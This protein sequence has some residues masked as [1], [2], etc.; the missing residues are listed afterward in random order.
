MKHLKYGESIADAVQNLPFGSAI[1]TEGIAEQLAERF[2]LPYEQARKLTNV[3]L[4]RMTDKG[5]IER[6]Q[7]G[8][9]CHVKETVFGKV[10]P[11]IDKTVMETL[12]EQD[13]AKIGYEFGASLFNR[14]G[15]STLAPQ[16]I[17]ITTNRYRT[18]LPERCHIKVRRPPTVVTD[19]NWKY[20]QLIDVVSELPNAHIDADHPEQLLAA[21]IKKQQLDGLTLILTARRYY[22]QKAVLQVIDLLKLIDTPREID[23]L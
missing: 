20:F 9:Y 13:G 15:L 18:K 1:R 23:T 8:M 19:Q 5:E 22:P 3:K 14:L 2:T 12:T 6:L 21:H 16:Y 17:A 11:D 7:K 10:T 4:K